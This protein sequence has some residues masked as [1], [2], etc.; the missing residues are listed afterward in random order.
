M[1]KKHGFVVKGASAAAVKTG[2]KRRGGKRH[3]KSAAKK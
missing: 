1:A 3:T 2:K